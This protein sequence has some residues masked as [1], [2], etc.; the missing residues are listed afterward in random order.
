MLLQVSPRLVLCS[1]GAVVSCAAVE[2]E[3]RGV[4]PDGWAGDAQVEDGQHG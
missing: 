2:E 4:F 3:R 1:S